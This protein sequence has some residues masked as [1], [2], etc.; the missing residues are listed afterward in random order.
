MFSH[1]YVCLFVCFLC[2]IL[3]WSTKRNSLFT[4]IRFSIVCVFVSIRFIAI[5][6]KLEFC[7]CCC[8]RSCC[9]YRRQTHYSYWT[10][11]ECL[12][13]MLIKSTA[14]KLW[15]ELYVRA[16]G[17]EN[18]LEQ[19]QISDKKVKS[20]FGFRCDQKSLDQ[21]G[22]HHHCD[23]NHLNESL[24]HDS[25]TP[26]VAKIVIIRLYFQYNQWNYIYN[27]KL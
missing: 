25:I 3:I 27:I 21:C 14:F 12:T 5:S 9:W 24:L 18:E 16:S 1:S 7:F 10:N 19:Q 13:T 2:W 11:V 8:F 4:Q 17:I 15:V 26:M 23:S 22:H 20:I 6:T